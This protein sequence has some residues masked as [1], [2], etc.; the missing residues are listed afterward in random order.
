MKACLPTKPMYC[1]REYQASTRLNLFI[2]INLVSSFSVLIL[3][4]LILNNILYMCVYN[5]HTVVHYIPYVPML[6]L[7]IVDI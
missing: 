5:S 2:L 6:A 7:P 3:K 4:Q 1:S